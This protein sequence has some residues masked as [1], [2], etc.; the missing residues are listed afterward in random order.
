MGQFLLEVNTTEMKFIFVFLSI[1]LC[2]SVNKAQNQYNAVW[3]GSSSSYPIYLSHP[4]YPIYLSHPSHPSYP[5][6]PIYPSYPS[7]PGTRAYNI[8][9][10]CSFNCGCP[11]GQKYHP[12][13]K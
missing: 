10:E 8:N 13:L 4:S 5:I 3:N 12:V 6:Y 1:L 11:S 2:A 7:Y 9:G